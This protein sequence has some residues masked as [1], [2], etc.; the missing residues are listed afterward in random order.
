[1]PRNAF[2]VKQTSYE[3]IALIFDIRLAFLLGS[4][5]SWAARRFIFRSRFFRAPGKKLGCQLSTAV[6][7][8]R[9]VMMTTPSDSD[10]TRDVEIRPL[11]H[12]YQSEVHAWNCYF[13]RAAGA[14]MVCWWAASYY[15]YINR[16][17]AKVGS[18]E[19]HCKCRKAAMLMRRD[20]HILI[21]VVSWSRGD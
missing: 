1:M 9:S 4:I 3:L 19:L 12:A 5:W 11:A 21:G 14:C 8:G 17:L 7:D 16:N 20:I 6:Y 10:A 2:L 18:S 15:S 13:M